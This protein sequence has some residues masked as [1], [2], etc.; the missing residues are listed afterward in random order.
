MA[1]FLDNVYDKTYLRMIYLIAISFVLRLAEMYL[2][3]AEGQ[4]QSG[5]VDALNN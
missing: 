2:I 1:K 4:L 5:S 3:K